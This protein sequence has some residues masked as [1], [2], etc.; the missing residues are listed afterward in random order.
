MPDEHTRADD[1]HD[2][3]HAHL[4]TLAEAARR[5]SLSVRTVRRMIGYGYLPGYRVGPRALRVH[6]DDVDAA[7]KRLPPDWVDDGPP[8]DDDGP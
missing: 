6:A 8:D 2:D 7:V 5:L 4:I 1:E 3:G